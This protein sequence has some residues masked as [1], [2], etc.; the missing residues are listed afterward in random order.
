M[1]TAGRAP[2]PPTPP[3]DEPLIEQGDSPIV[4]A[5]YVLGGGLRQVSETREDEGELGRARRLAFFSSVAAAAQP[6][7]T[8]PPRPPFYSGRPLPV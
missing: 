4:E 6:F 8:F 5:D 2:S 1:T 7:L 3:A